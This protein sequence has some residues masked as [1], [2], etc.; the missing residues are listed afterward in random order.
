MAEIWEPKVFR[1]R[2]F[3]KIRISCRFHL[4]HFGNEG[5]FFLCIFGRRT[6]CRCPFFDTSRFARNTRTWNLPHFG[7]FYTKQKI[8]KFHFSMKVSIKH[9]RGAHLGFWRL[10]QI[11]RKLKKNKRAKNF[12]AEFEI[13]RIPGFPYK[14]PPQRKM[15]LMKKVFKWSKTLTD[16]IS[17]QKLKNFSVQVRKTGF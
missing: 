6:R 5:Y 9:L 7:H 3:E 1:K 11:W 16:K 12:F 4:G 10:V 8:P 14:E 13:L 17:D 15:L 2:K